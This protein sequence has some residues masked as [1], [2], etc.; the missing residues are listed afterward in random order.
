MK[1]IAIISD[2]H[3]LLREEVKEILKDCHAILH[4]GDI[5][6]AETYNNLNKSGKVYAVRGNNDG[7]WAAGIPDESE[8]I[9]YGIRFYMIHD[10]SM[11]SQEKAEKADVVIYGHSHR[12]EYYEEDH[13]IYLN[14]GS[15]GRER[16]KLP[17]TMAVLY[18]NEETGEINVKRIDFAKDTD[19]LQRQNA[20]VE[21]NI[22]EERDMK[23]I[24]KHVLKG[25]RR[26]RSIQEMASR[27]DIS[28]KL[29]EQI[30]RI[31]VTHPGVDA[32]GIMNKMEV[33]AL[34]Q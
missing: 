16:F 34:Y 25:M 22:M 20:A 32:E 29:V 7:S 12:F 10:K 27:Y 9:L 14:P 11:I 4:G 13:K 31:Y 6:N 2:T 26:G 28:E 15:C 18:V 3:G 5:D 19:K 1:K 30:C 24:I 33:S 23:K 17:L 8:V 21:K